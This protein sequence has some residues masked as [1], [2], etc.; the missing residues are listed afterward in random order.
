[1]ATG[2]GCASLLVTVRPAMI[3]VDAPKTTSLSQWRFAGRREIATYEA[4]AYAGTENFQ[5]RCRSSAVAK[6][7][8]S[9]A[10]PDGND[11]GPLPSGRS[12]RVVYFN[13]SV[14][15]SAIASDWIRSIPTCDTFGRSFARPYA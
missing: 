7:N 9:A 13:V 8:V 10:W 3:P 11:V 1:M 12:R 4:N 15:P 14:R 6:A 2:K 5:F